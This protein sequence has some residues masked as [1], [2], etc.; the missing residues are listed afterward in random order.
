[1]VNGK[2]IKIVD[3]KDRYIID[4]KNRCIQAGAE[5]CQPQGNLSGCGVD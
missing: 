2:Y 5:L 1:M 4:D 3:Y